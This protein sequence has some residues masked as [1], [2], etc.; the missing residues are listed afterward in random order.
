MFVWMFVSAP[1]FTEPISISLI[2]FCLLVLEREQFQ[3]FAW[4]RKESFSLLGG[5]G[6]LNTGSESRAL[7]IFTPFL[8]MTTKGT[9]GLVAGLALFLPRKNGT[10][11][12]NFVCSNFRWEG[13]LLPG[14]RAACDFVEGVGGESP[15]K[16]ADPINFAYGS[17]CK[18]GL[19]VLRS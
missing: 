8:P 11:N 6:I 1:C 18:A 2:F 5:V 15:G 9:W 10:Y 3:R 13:A 17:H 12:S 19:H 16:A 4:K 7:L 14:L